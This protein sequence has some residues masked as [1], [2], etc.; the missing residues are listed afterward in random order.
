LTGYTLPA[1]SGELPLFAIFGYFVYQGTRSVDYLNRVLMIGL[2]VAYIA[3]VFLLLPHVQPKL[4]GHTDAKYLLMSVAII[5]TSFGFHIIIPSLATYLDRN[6]SSLKKAIW[7][8]SLIPLAVY[9]I[10]QLLTLGII[11]LTGTHSITQGYAQGVDGA[12]LL[13]ESLH[14]SSIAI[15]AR[16]FSFFAIVTSFLG[17]SLSLFDCLGDS[18]KIKKTQGG[19]ALLFALTFL[20]PLLFALSDPRAFLTALE[21]AGAFGVVILLGLLP[22]L[23]AWSNRY[24]KYRDG[25]YKVLGGKLCLIFVMLFSSLIIL[26]EF[27]NKL[28]LIRF[29]QSF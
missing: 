15:I 19:R 1:W 10:W 3:L 5:A 2:A 16:F 23:M 11:P 17:V 8:G 4:L 25:P 20:P 7:I 26:L 14:N 9:I 18:L 12:H 6:I 13:S 29:E 22:A 24:W 21:Y 27:A 28:G